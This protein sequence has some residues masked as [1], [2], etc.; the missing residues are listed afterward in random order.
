[1]ER[2]LQGKRTVQGDGTGD[3]EKLPLVVPIKVRDDV[4]GVL[5]TYK[6]AEAGE[7]TSE[8]ITLLETLA[9]QLGEALESAR[10]YQDTQR[11]AAREQLTRE[12]TDKMRRATSIEDIV[13]TAV[14]ELFGTMRT[15]RAFVRLGTTPPARSNGDERT[16]GQDDEGTG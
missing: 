14:D 9:D 2:A 7:W 3:G 10:L 11:R 5:D 1:M 15:S 6:P 12:I 8:E 13:R 4:I 16:R